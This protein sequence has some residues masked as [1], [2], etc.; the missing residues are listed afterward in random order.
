MAKYFP[1]DAPCIMTED[2]QALFILDE[3]TGLPA[4]LGR[5]AEIE[6][7]NNIN[8]ILY[9]SGTVRDYHTIEGL[10]QLIIDEELSFK[11]SMS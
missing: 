6:L 5:P 1:F 11:D 8:R 2:E 4:F 10:T 3:E 9:G 7:T